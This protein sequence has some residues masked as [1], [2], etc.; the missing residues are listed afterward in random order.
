MAPRLIVGL[1]GLVALAGSLLT[2]AVAQDAKKDDGKKDAKEIKGK[3]T[4]VDIDKMTFSIKPDAGEEMEFKVSDD[5]KFVG[6]NRGSSKEGIKDSRF[7]VGAQVTLV[8]D[9]TGKTLKEVR[10]PRR[11]GGGTKGKDKIEK[12][13]AKDAP[14]KDNKAPAKDAP[15]KDN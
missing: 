4:K 12:S 14:A 10:L 13:P 11:S 5:V 3:V 8:T 2:V 9:A 6:P 15:S 7:K 1:I